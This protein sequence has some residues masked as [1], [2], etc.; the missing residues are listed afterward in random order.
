MQDEILSIPG[1]GELTSVEAQLLHGNATV[2][3]ADPGETLFSPFM[4]TDAYW[5]LI[6]GRWRIIRRVLGVEQ[7]MFEGDRPG[8]W[9]GGVS[10]I[11]AVAPPAV[12][13]LAPSRLLRVPIAAM[14]R[15][16]ATNSTAAKTLLDGLNWGTEHVGGLIRLAV[17]EPS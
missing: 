4:P 1:F 10:L 3:R 13:I 7:F 17:S 14:E 11:D 2:I 15:M 16:A 9:T 8:S 6:A 5:F 12:T